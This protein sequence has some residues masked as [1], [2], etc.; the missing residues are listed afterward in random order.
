MHFIKKIAKF[1]EVRDCLGLRL[2]DEQSYLDFNQPIRFRTIP[3]PNPIQ[4]IDTTAIRY[5]TWEEDTRHI[6]SVVWGEDIARKKVDEYRLPEYLVELG[7]L[8]Q[9]IRK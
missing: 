3:A 5:N 7:T 8:E 9:K 6:L 1:G 2:E 4:A